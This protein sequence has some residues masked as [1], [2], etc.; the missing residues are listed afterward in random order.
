[1]SP[2]NDTFAQRMKRV[3]PVLLE[4]PG[5]LAGAGCSILAGLTLLYLLWV[6]L[7]FVFG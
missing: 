2:Q 6:L 5:V 3:L 1:M 7:R 4:G